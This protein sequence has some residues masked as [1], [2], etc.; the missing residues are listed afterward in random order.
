MGTC[1]CILLIVTFLHV[2]TSTRISLPA[3]TVSN[4]HD[5]AATCSHY[6]LDGTILRGTC[7]NEDGT[8]QKSALELN[9]CIGN[10]KGGLTVND[11]TLSVVDLLTFNF[12]GEQSRFQALYHMS[13]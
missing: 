10:A 4:L 1:F 7:A 6:N 8:S 12:S 9:Q 5:F 13:S 11:F 2:A 3:Q